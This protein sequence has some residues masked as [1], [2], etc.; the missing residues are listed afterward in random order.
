MTKWRRCKPLSLKRSSIF[1]GLFGH[2]GP[3]APKVSK[4]ASHLISIPDLFRNTGVIYGKPILDDRNAGVLIYTSFCI[5]QQQLLLLLL[6][7]GSS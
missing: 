6:L 5:Q 2:A 7:L 3:W 1:L 4:E